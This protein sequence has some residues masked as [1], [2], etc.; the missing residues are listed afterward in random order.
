MSVSPVAPRMWWVWP[1]AALLLCFLA[2]ACAARGRSAVVPTAT[3]TA[4]PAP[5]RFLAVPTFTPTVTPTPTSTFTPTFTPTV[6]PTPTTVQGEGVYANL[7]EHH[8]GS[9]RL[10]RRGDRVEAHLVTTRSA[11]QAWAPLQVLFTLP[12]AFRPPFPILRRGMG[13]PVRADGSPDPAHPD[14]RPFRLQLEPDGRV[15]Y[16]DHPGVA[17]RGYLAYNLKLAWGTTPA[18]NDQTVLDL[19]AE[20]TR[21]ISNPVLQPVL[22]FAE[23][24]L[25]ALETY[26]LKGAIPPEIGQLSQLQRLTLRVSLAR[27]EAG[28]TLWRP[29]PR[30]I[31]QLTQLTHLDLQSSQLTGAI[32]PELGR[33]HNLTDLDLYEN[34]LTGEIPPELGQL[35]NLET[36]RLSVNRLTGPI[37]PE[38]GHLHNLTKLSLTGNQLTALPPEI[39]QLHNLGTLD[40]RENQLTALPPELGQLQSLIDLHLDYNQLTALPPEL[41]Q[42]QSLTQL[43]LR[44]NQL[45]ALPPELFQLPNL[46]ILYVSGNPGI[47]C[48]Q[49]EWR[50]T[51]ILFRALQ[52]PPLPFCTA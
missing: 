18:A 36:L 49:K 47:D 23:G 2:A 9:Y 17:G 48:L 51:G 10:Q 8:D 30:E 16:L 29:L 19:L 15:R 37:P 35:R 34:Q 43:Y 12:P 13:Q 14:P 44:G 26:D 25:T 24:R 21:G 31:G 42:L 27:H 7:V 28:G 41:A 32:P 11:L 38:F 5:V 1:I 45:T 4:T 33:L 20:L 46:T 40:L 22:Q 39:G 6:T 3:P 52:D 50:D